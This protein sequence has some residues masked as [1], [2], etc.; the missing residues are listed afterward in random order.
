MHNYYYYFSIPYLCEI[1]KSSVPGFTLIFASILLMDTVWRHPFSAV[2]AGPSMAGKSS[3]VRRLIENRK[4]MIHPSPNRVYWCYAEEQPMYAT[5]LA[6][7]DVTFVQGFPDIS[8]AQGALLIFDDLMMESKDNPFLTALATRGCH[9][10]NISCIQIVQNLF[11]GG[12]TARINSQYIVLMKNPADKLQVATL[13]RQLFPDNTKYFKE[14]Y[15]DATRKPHGYLL[16]DLG[17]A[18]PDH[19]RQRTCIFPGE[20][21]IV[22]T[23]IN[24]G[25]WKCTNHQ[26]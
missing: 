16:L 11:F 21:T 13:A 12:R 5:L 24:R 25:T 22:Y 15:E 23:P 10:R 26:Y 9:H 3:F 2:V 1:Y 6:D 20:V 8:E 4:E 19:T 14:A 18:T 7:P 17:Q